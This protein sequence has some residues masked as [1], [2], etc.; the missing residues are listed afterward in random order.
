M[1]AVPCAHVLP[2]SGLVRVSGECGTS[3]EVPTGFSARL[4]TSG[5]FQVLDGLSRTP[6]ASS[7]LFTKNA[8]SLYTLHRDRAPLEHGITSAWLVIRLKPTEKSVAIAP[9][10][11]ESWKILCPE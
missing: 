3:S 2:V 4:G 10:V 7:V 9:D 5:N 8:F 11:S 1:F 6:R